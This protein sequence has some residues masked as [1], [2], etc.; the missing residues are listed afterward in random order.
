MNKKIIY[1]YVICG[2]GA[3]GLSLI[4]ELINDN[5]F[6]NH[7]ILLLD[8]KKKITN[9]RTWTYWEKGEGKH[10]DILKK[11]WGKAYFSSKN[12][13]LTFETKPYQFKSIRGI[14]F[15]D[16]ILKKIS[17]YK[18][19]KVLN[20]EV[21]KIIDQND[22]VKVITNKNTFKCKKAFSSIMK[23]ISDNKKHPLLKQ[24]FIGWFIKTEKNI[25]N[26]DKIT[27]MDFDIDQK[28]NTR[29]MYILPFKK[30][31]ALI[32][33]TLFSK[34]IL[35]DNEYETEIKNYIDEKLKV[36]FKII[37]KE[38]GVIPMTSFEFWKFNSKNLIY[39]G[40][41]GGWTKS[42]TGFTFFKTIKKSKELKEYIKTN[43]DLDKFEKK[44]KYWLY[45]SVL[46]DILY[47]NNSL[48]EKVFETMFKKN[49]PK[50]ILDF[51]DEKTT[52]QEDI[53]LFLNF[54]K[55]IFLKSL[56]KRLFKTIFL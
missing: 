43:K 54:P 49:S 16:K 56:V 12:L 41:A 15:Y 19:I 39:I 21:K 1:D 28:N 9:D 51:L 36:N 47:E 20:E 31:E 44:N 18:N 32:E 48:G 37:E 26:D 23:P 42:S 34:N 5:F 17:K 25:F 52:F 4:N 50:L 40:T 53:K 22:I 30:N 3:A 46:I 29:F 33:Y 8:K 14:N 27:F 13:K 11:K 2:S 45:D 35:N 10:D 38:N 6:L 55:I 7:R 24:H